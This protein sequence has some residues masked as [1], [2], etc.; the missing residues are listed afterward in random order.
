MLVIAVVIG[1]LNLE[2]IVA[3]YRHD[4][5]SAVGYMTRQGHLVLFVGLTVLSCIFLLKHEPLAAA[6][7]ALVAVPPFC[8]FLLYHGSLIETAGS[9][10]LAGVT[11]TM[12]WV[13]LG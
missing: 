12:L 6:A 9:F 11:A 1:A 3:L 8:V 7:L 10:N 4:S 5:G 2:W 13:T